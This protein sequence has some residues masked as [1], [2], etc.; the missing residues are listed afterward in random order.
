LREFNVDIDK[1][2]NHNLNLIDKKGFVY[3][4]NA[5]IS[6]LSEEEK[7]FPTE[8]AD[9]TNEEL[10]NK[11]AVFTALYASVSVNEAISMAEVAGYER[12]LEITKSQ[13]MQLSNLSKVTDKR[14]EAAADK[15]VISVQE[16]LTVAESKLKLFAALR[17]SYEKYISLFSR[18]LTSKLEERKLQ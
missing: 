6:S 7:S 9:F 15:S 12:E 4:S 16:K 3:P 10:L 13:V 5:D 11:M 18:A 8:V 17:A 14:Q 2:N 1:L